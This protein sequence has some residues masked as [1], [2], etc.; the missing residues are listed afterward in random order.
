MENHTSSPSNNKKKSHSRALRE[1]LYPSLIRQQ[2]GNNCSK[3]YKN[4]EMK[5]FSDINMH[6]IAISWQHS[7]LASS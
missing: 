2:A 4:Y 1:I 5:H 6:K 3:I 7:I